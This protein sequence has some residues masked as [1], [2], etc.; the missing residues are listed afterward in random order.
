MKDQSQ[1]AKPGGEEENV[2][3]ETVWR[4]IRNVLSRIVHLAGDTDVQGTIKGI[5]GGVVLEGSNLWILICSSFI[6][7]IGLDTNSPAVIIG[8]MLISPLMSPILGIG[9]CTAI[10][11]REYLIKSL[12][13]FGVALGLSLLVSIFYFTI[14]PFGQFTDEMRARTSPTVLD[15]FV[16]FFG[17]LA[18]IIAGSRSDK[19]NAIPGVAIATALMPPLCTSGFGLAT[20]R[21][22]VFLGAFYLFFINAVLISISTYLIVK[23]LRF[24]L[25]EQMNPHLAKKAYRIVYLSL[26]LLLVPS[27]LFLFNSL[28]EIAQQT[29][30]N[31]FISRHIHADIAQGVQWTYKPDGDSVEVLRVYYFGQYIRPDSVAK[32]R[33]R[34][35]GQLRRHPLLRISAPDSVALELTPTDRPPDEEKKIIRQELADL[36]AGVLAMRQVQDQEVQFQRR[37]ID[38]LVAEIDR[39][40]RDSIPLRAIELEAKAFFPEL[41]EISFGKALNIQYDT[42]AKPHDFIALVKWNGSMARRRDFGEWEAR[43]NSYLQA[44]LGSDKVKLLSER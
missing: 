28:R 19:T 31:N 42:A 38:S 12:R 3:L 39:V 27:F 10:N 9:L 13:N 24:P 26:A 4:F 6:A 1:P 15:A 43:L 7:C 44:K 30:I 5:K 23:F 29:E 33:Q 14:T 17:G 16:A 18:G 35:A 22:E 37:Q 21:W 41:E 32:L 2:Q 8:A 20:G 36:R 34:L 11:D 25:K 40:R